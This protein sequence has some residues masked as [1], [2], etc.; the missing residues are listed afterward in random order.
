MH[1]QLNICI[2][3]ESRFHRQSFRPRLEYHGKFFEIAKFLHGS[4]T[5]FGTMDFL[6]DAMVPLLSLLALVE[7][8]PDPTSAF[9]VVQNLAMRRLIINHDN[10]F[11]KRHWHNVNKCSVK[12][13]SGNNNKQEKNVLMRC[14]GVAMQR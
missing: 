3:S 13:K 6:L 10:A 9:P 1:I 7:E 14:G 8:A 11:H 2:V 12:R 5:F 4:H